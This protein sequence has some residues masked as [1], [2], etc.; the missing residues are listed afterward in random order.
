LGI[1]AR[2]RAR[3]KAMLT[4]AYWHAWGR[5]PAVEVVVLEGVPRTAT[6]AEVHARALEE[7]AVRAATRRAPLVTGLTPLGEAVAHRFVVDGAPAG[8]AAAETDGFGA[9]RPATRIDLVLTAA[10]PPAFRG[11]D[12]RSAHLG[13]LRARARERRRGW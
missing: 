11:A 6:F 2:A 8:A 1:A 9:L 12:Q 5:R 3:T 13:A 4:V 10:L 7:G